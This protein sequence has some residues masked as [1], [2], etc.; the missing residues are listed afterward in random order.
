MH[1]ILVTTDDCYYRF[2]QYKWEEWRGRVG[3]YGIV[4]DQQL[5]VCLFFL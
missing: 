2:P 4:G 3:S 5:Q 1:A